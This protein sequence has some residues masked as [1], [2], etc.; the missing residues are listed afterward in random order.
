[1]TI[2]AT[3]PSLRRSHIQHIK[4]EA[5]GDADRLARAEITRIAEPGDPI[6]GSL[7]EHYG[8]QGA[9]E[10]VRQ[11]VLE[12][13]F[14]QAERERAYGEGRR[15]NLGQVVTGWANRAV[16]AASR[17]PDDLAGG[18]LL[19]PGDPG[20]PSQLN[21]LGRLRPYGLWL[22][23]QEDLRF[24]CLRSVS[25]VGARA[26]TAYGTHVA[27]EL[28]AGLSDRSWTVISGGAYG[29]DAAAHRGALAGVAPTVVVLACGTDVSY[30]SAHQDLFQAVRE[31]GLLISESPPGVHP[32]RMRFLVRNRVIA[33]LSR[34]TVVVQ[35]AIRSGA[36]NTAAHA[37]ALNRQLMAVPGPI[38]C[39]VSTGCHALIRQNRA[40]CVTSVAEVIELVG[41][42]GEDLA[43]T[44]R[45]PVHPRDS[46]N[47]ET[48]RV[49]DAVPAR[50][51][52]GL[53]TIANAA[54]LPLPTT[55]ACLGGLESA[56]FIRRT[57]DGWRLSPPSP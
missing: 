5:T 43:P 22:D 50:I 34:G 31:R 8:P 40:T 54:G 12:P 20:W 28:S 26:A 44:A 7:I 41:S 10:Q 36:L 38:T 48:K 33:A 30:P 6:M 13:E 9:L 32:T 53:A 17:A 42:I 24:A 35:A 15:L 21:D 56:G 1:M 23:G 57:A 49:L 46:L 14:A 52:Q 18:R 3:P 16:S 55:L 47:E 51:P 2:P 25:L 11:G 19:I 39:D 4:V 27:A 29:I 45:G 37:A